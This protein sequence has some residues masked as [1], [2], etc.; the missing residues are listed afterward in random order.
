VSSPLVDRKTYLDWEASGGSSAVQR[1]QAEVERR[2]SA[3]EEPVLAPE[4]AAALEEI[5]RA[6]AA[7]F[8]LRALPG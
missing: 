1:A 3:P 4:V 7:P 5:L 8:G 6:E 2:L